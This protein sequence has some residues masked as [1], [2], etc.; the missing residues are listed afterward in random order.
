MFIKLFKVSKD[1]DRPVKLDSNAQ[2][3]YYFRIS[4]KD[5]EVLRNNKNYKIIDTRKDGIKFQNDKLEEYNND[6][7]T[8]RENYEQQQKTVVDEVLRIASKLN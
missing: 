2:N 3:G 8:I 4:R 5:D 6:F 7:V 1:I